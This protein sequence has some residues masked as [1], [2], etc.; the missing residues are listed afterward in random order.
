MKGSLTIWEVVPV[1][2][3]V[4]HWRKQWLQQAMHRLLSSICTRNGK[5]MNKKHTS[6]DTPTLNS[7]FPVPVFFHLSDLTLNWFPL[8]ASLLIEN[9]SNPSFSSWLMLQCQLCLFWF[10]HDFLFFLSHIRWIPQLSAPKHCW[11]WSTALTAGAWWLW[12]PVTTIAQTSWEAVWP[13]K[14][15]LI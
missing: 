9:S 6:G 11:R 10:N 4:W 13:T 3:S 14:E 12:S 1:F 5:Q 2:L 15:T 8:E 7:S